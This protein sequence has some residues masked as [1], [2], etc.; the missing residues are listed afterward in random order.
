M[1]KIDVAFLVILAGVFGIYLLVSELTPYWPPPVVTHQIAQ[2]DASLQALW[3]RSNIFIGADQQSFLV[4]GAGSVFILGSDERRT[5]SKV[6]AYEA[7]TGEQ[8]WAT[9]EYIGTALLYQAGQLLVGGIGEVISFNPQDG[10]RIWTKS[11]PP[12]RSVYE[13]YWI[14]NVL[15][16]DMGTRYHAMSPQTGEILHSVHGRDFEAE[17]PFWRNPPDGWETYLGGKIDLNRA[18]GKAIWDA[19]ENFISKVAINQARLFALTDDGQLLQID[20]TTGITTRLVLFE[21]S[22]F[23]RQNEAGNQFHFY[24][25]SDANYLFAYLGDSRQLFA[26][27]LLDE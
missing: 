14:D 4:S 22:P 16:A 2:M 8:R 11:V 25:S 21:P 12:G 6:I 18:T 13:L 20:L 3:V 23:I 15:Y 24:V 9:R 27:E 19:E 7:A 1:R 10:S 26:F 5:P 17:P